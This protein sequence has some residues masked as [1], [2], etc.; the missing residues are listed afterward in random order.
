MPNEV[1]T[2]FTYLPFG[3]GR[4]K[5]IGDQ[6]A[7]FESVVGLSMFMRRYEFELAPGTT[8]GMTTGTHACHMEHTM[9]AWPHGQL[10]VCI[11][12]LT[13]CRL[14]STTRCCFAK[15]R[16]ANLSDAG[17]VSHLCSDM[18]V[19]VCVCVCLGATIHT[20]NGLNVILK[21]RNLPPS[22]AQPQPAQVQ[23]LNVPQLAV[24]AYAATA[25]NGAAAPAAQQPVL[26]TTSG[27]ADAGSSNG[28][29]QPG[30]AAT[31]A[32]AG[33]S[34]SAGLLSNA[35]PAMAAVQDAVDVAAK[36]AGK[37]PFSQLFS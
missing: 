26:A 29:L 17:G 11:S 34:A 32:A 16:I 18:C 28:V 20:T 7:I 13:G 22:A 24:P 19:C 5:C 35:A 15:H 30:L 8:V 27:S 10:F 3:G 14:R 2:D 33:A 9:H 31:A 12:A 23:T 6:F 21:R 37:C 25:V 4:R 1:T 36:T